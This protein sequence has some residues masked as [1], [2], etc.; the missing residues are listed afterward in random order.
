MNIVEFM[1]AA[2]AT[3][4]VVGVLVVWLYREDI[5]Y[6]GSIAIAVCA[7]LS[8]WSLSFGL[9]SNPN[10]NEAWV[11]IFKSVKPFVVS[12]VFYGLLFLITKRRC[13]TNN[14]IQWIADKS[15]SH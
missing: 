3:G 13:L 14:A 12:T 8:L 15:A 11:V 4:I 9:I 2:T 7:L 10:K 6:F 5:R 1:V